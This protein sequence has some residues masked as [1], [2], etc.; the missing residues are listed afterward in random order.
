M[1]DIDSR[2]FASIE[3]A[4]VELIT[5]CD[6]S[7]VRLE[8]Q[9]KIVSG[10]IAIGYERYKN[11]AILSV[12][13]QAEGMSFDRVRAVLSY[14]GA[15]SLMAQGVSGG[16]GFFGRGMK[17]AIF[18]LGHGWIESIF[19]GRYSRVDLFRGED[20]RYLFDDGDTDRPAEDQDYHRLHLVP[21]GTGSKVTI[22][23][24]NPQTTIPYF[25]SL[26]STVS[27]NIYLRDILWRRSVEI[28]NRNLKGK[29]RI[30]QTLAY[31]EPEA[32]VLIGPDFLSSFRYHEETY[33]FFITLKKALESRSNL[34]RG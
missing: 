27:N 10:K 16:R 30:S 19:E 28:T 12:S 34:E 24:D 26:C 6:D 9:G 7:Y 1:I 29:K 23:V 4:L 17:Q 20:G 2:R 33:P 13:D 31:E 25:S 32:E 15:H 21:G 8:R 22:V 14:G 3:K 5:N 18:G 11:G